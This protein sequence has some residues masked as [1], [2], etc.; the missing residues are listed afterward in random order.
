MMYAHCDNCP[1]CIRVDGDEDG[2][3]VGGGVCL[4]CD[5]NMDYYDAPPC[6]IIIPATPTE[7]CDVC[8]VEVR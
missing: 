8:N 6:R 2:S 5:G 4:Q 3:N 1:R 7:W